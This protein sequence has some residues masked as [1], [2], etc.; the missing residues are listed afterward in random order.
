MIIDIYLWFCLGLLIIYMCM[1]LTVAKQWYPLKRFVKSIISLIVSIVIG[2]DALY[3]CAFFTGITDVIFEQLESATLTD[4][5]ILLV[6]ND[7][8]GAKMGFLFLYIITG[9]VML[10]GIHRFGDYIVGFTTDE[11]ELKRQESVWLNSK[12]PKFLRSKKYE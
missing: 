10:W 2:L 7:A 3:V 4:M 5:Y 12:M 8:M 9:V 1:G 11:I 6:G